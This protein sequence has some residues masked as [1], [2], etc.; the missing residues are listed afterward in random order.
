MS[1]GF[2]G[3]HPLNK[4]CSVELHPEES[5]QSFSIPESRSMSTPKHPVKKTQVAN[6]PVTSTHKTNNY[7][8]STLTS[9][10]IN[11]SLQDR[12]ENKKREKL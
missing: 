12:H 3:W 5:Q 4:Q 9:N 10:V 8:L 7:R 1:L 2:S 6:Q 11:A